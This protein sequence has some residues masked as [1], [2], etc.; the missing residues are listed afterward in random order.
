MILEKKRFF[1]KGFTLTEVLIVIVIIAII[2]SLVLPRFSGQA[3]KA[4]TSEAVNIM[5][6]IRRGILS[7]YD[8]HEAWPPSMGPNAQDFKDTLGVDFTVAFVGGEWKTPHG[9]KITYT[10]PA[11]SNPGTFSTIT[12]T[13]SFPNELYLDVPTG[14][15][16]GKGDYETDTGRYWPYLC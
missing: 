12:A 2:A 13:M 16:S 9:W 1:E 15:W 10:S 3:E 14:A 4:R 7:Y 8:A 5:S 6:S 11:D